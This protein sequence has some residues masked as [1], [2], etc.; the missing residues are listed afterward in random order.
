M[1]F[2]CYCTKGWRH[3]I[4]ST[5]CWMTW[6]RGQFKGGRGVSGVGRKHFEGQRKWIPIVA[7]HARIPVFPTWYVPCLSLHLYQQNSYHGFKETHWQLG[8]LSG[9]KNIFI[10]LF[11]LVQLIIP[12]YNMQYL[13]HWWFCKLW[14]D[15]CWIGLGC[16]WDIVWLLY[17]ID[18]SS[19]CEGAKRA[20]DLGLHQEGRKYLYLL[21]SITMMQQFNTKMP[22]VKT[23]IT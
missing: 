12:N 23:E 9:S 1:H 13:S 16:S 20:H 22:F 7:S 19:L 5:G 6:W 17:C 14:V 2:C 3:C 15:W 4:Y 10:Y 21:K 8:K 18:F 11:Q